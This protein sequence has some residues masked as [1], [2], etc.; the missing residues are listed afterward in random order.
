M[1]DL[2]FRPAVRVAD[3]G[4]ERRFG[5]TRTAVE[6][7]ADVIAMNS[8]QV[9]NKLND[10]ASN[11]STRFSFSG[12]VRAKISRQIEKTLSACAPK[13]LGSTHYDPDVEA[14]GAPQSVVPYQAARG[15]ERF[16]AP[17][18]HIDSRIRRVGQ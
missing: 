18:L 2:S 3:R 6:L 10:L 7:R 5:V 16:I 8:R 17:A 4:N 1:E 12:V 13:F 11:N 15:T 9:S 14:L